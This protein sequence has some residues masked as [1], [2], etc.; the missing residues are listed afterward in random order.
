MSHLQWQP[1]HYNSRQLCT[2]EGS[3]DAEEHYGTLSDVINEIPKHHVIIECGDFNAHLGE[4]TVRH[5]FHTQTNKNYSSF[6]SLGSD[7]R[8]VTARIRLSLRM[9]KTPAKKK[10]YEWSSLRN[11]E[12]QE[13]Y[14]VTGQNRFTELSNDSDNVTEQYGKLVQV[15][16]EAAEKLLPVKKRIRRREIADDPRVEQTRKEVQD[17]FTN[18]QNDANTESQQHLQKRKEELKQVYQ[19]IQEEE[20]DEMITQVKNAD[21]KSKHGESWRLINSIT[22]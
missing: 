11:T 19:D 8:L 12:L 16:A 22:G 21:A 7:H 2:I 3:N 4:D 17:A 10:S 18:Y 5:T 6:S 15:N 14:T 20:L 13:L 9:C 1:K